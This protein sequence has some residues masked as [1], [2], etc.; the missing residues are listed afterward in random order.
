MLSR[1]SKKITRL[2]SNDDGPT[3]VE[4]AILLAIIVGTIVA[5]VSYVGTEVKATHEM[6]GTALD[7]TLND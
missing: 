3:A 1:L 7:G 5:S 4:Y 6:I 2:L